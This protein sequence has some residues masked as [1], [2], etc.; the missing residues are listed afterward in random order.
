MKSTIAIVAAAMTACSMQPVS[1]LSSSDVDK[2]H[3]RPSFGSNKFDMNIILGDENGVVLS[4][5]K[6]SRIGAE[7]KFA[8][9]RKFIYPKSYSLPSNGENSKFPTTPATPLK[10]DS[11]ET[12]WTVSLKP[13]VAGGVIILEGE[14][15]HV[16]AKLHRGVFGEGSDPIVAPVSSVLGKKYVTVTENKGEMPL[17]SKNVYPVT[18]RVL[19]NKEYKISLSDGTNLK[20][21]LNEN[22]ANKTEHPTPYP[23][24]S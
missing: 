24:R 14:I 16:S 21:T 17:I 3:R 4:G 9:L 15:T 18:I 12:G 13:R 22:K 8:K 19:P 7:T 1:T 20:L 23:P 2:L 11:L 5:S 6:L 10:F